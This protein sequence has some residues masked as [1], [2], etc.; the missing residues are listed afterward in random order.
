MVH[1]TCSILYEKD[2]VKNVKEYIYV[3][4][5]L[6]WVEAVSECRSMNAE[7]AL[8]ESEEQNKK[9]SGCK[10]YGPGRKVYG[11]LPIFEAV[12]KYHP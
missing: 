10:V 7:L 9:G 3:G 5:N 2:I 12:D 1:I 8:I 4:K 6:N 11:P